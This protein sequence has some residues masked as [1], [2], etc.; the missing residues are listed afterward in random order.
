MNDFSI[1][2]IDDERLISA[3]C[4]DLKPVKLIHKN[5][6]FTVNQ[7]RD[8]YTVEP[9]TR[10]VI[11]LST[12]DDSSVIMVKQHRPVMNDYTLEL[13]AGGVNEDEEPI[14]AAR[15]E[16][17]EE[18]GIYIEDIDRFSFLTPIASSPNRD[19]CLLNILH[20]DITCDEFNSKKAHDHEISSVEKFSYA[21]VEKILISGEIYISVP[22]AIIGR[23]LLTKRK[24]I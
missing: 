23:F 20:V 9:N 14:Y 3:Q 8:F 11:I 15:R 2:L 24:S 4:S 13:P 12:L 19:P 18:T 22:M 17:R 7:R 21:E 5:L 6:W 10:Q 16:L 1:P